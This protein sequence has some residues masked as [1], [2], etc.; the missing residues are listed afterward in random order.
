MARASN[1]GGTPSTR[2]VTGSRNSPPAV[3]CQPTI[4]IGRTPSGLPHFF[5]RTIPKAIDAVPANPASTPT[6]SIPAARPST[7][8]PTPAAPITAHAR[9]QNSSRSFSTATARNTTTK[10]WA[11]PSVAATPPGRCSAEMKSNGKKNPMLSRPR[12]ADRTSH[13]PFGSAPPRAN[14][15]RPAG[16]ARAR[17]AN[18]G[19]PAGRK[20][21]VTRYVVPQTSGAK[22]ARA[23]TAASGRARRRVACFALSRPVPLSGAFTPVCAVGVGRDLTDELML[24]RSYGSMN[25]SNT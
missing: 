11:A 9:R 15:T 22:A 14:A 20:S 13:T 3:S 16:S 5:V 4:A 1:T 24:P 21:V 25:E 12:A 7:T 18:K 10:G 19:C 6:R 17:P 2:S 8:N 23:V